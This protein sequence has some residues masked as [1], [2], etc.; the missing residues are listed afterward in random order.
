MAVIK[1]AVAVAALLSSA[2]A[3]PKQAKPFE[4]RQNLPPADERAQGVIDT[5]R[6][7]WEGYVHDWVPALYKKLIHEKILQI[8]IPKR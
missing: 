2:S 4:T 1:R 3:L 7:A 8:C 6:T 5:F